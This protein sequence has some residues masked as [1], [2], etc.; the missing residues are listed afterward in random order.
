MME[1]R[2]EGM[3]LDAIAHEMD[4]S[5]RV[6]WRYLNGVPRGRQRATRGGVEEK[7]NE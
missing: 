7:T 3:S 4:R 6:V 5:Q 1:L 2:R